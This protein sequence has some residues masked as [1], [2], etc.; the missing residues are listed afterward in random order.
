MC[1]MGAGTSPHCIFRDKPLIVHVFRAPYGG[2]WED[3]LED[4]G[5][6][7]CVSPAHPP[8]RAALGRW[9]VVRAPMMVSGAGIERGVCRGQKSKMQGFRCHAWTLASGGPRLTEIRSIGSCPIAV[10]AVG[11]QALSGA[12]KGY[13][14]RT[15]GLRGGCGGLASA[16]GFVH[17]ILLSTPMLENWRWSAYR[18][19]T[20]GA[21]VAAGP[22]PPPV[23]AAYERAT[24]TPVSGL[25]VRA[26][27]RWRP[28]EL[29]TGRLEQPAGGSRRQQE[30][31]SGGR[32]RSRR[33]RPGGRS[34]VPSFARTYQGAGG[35]AALIISDT[36]RRR[37]AQ[38]SR[39][40]SR[41]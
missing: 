8:N 17:P 19:Q 29:R 23:C 9:S 5:A 15:R 39:R 21:P 35:G 24:A 30:L 41:V 36:A 1:E 10:C 26:S 28:V 2:M 38:L 3:Q 40:P 27:S 4:S 34:R 7:A 31:G 33:S 18:P 16:S 37:S 32:C 14:G 13:A 11:C 22:P 20:W 25:R 6:V 12:M